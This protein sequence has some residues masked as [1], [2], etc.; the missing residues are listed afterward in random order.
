MQSV[1]PYSS[2][3]HVTSHPHKI[4]HG[5]EY[6]H[7]EKVKKH[8]KRKT[9]KTGV[10]FWEKRVQFLSCG[11]GEKKLYCVC[12]SAAAAGNE[13]P[14]KKEKA[15]WKRKRKHKMDKE[16]ERTHGTRRNARAACTHKPI[17]K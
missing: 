5:L 13:S 9:K 7:T 1:G 14:Y 11:N 2:S 12:A 15:C 6:A 16:K 3:K 17:L 10:F 4:S 8:K